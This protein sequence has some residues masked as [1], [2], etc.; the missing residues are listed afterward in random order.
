MN[1]RPAVFLDRDGTI[2][3]EVNYLSDPSQVELLPGAAAA[4]ARWNAEG[5]AVVV[6]TNQAGVARG[7]FAESRIVEVHRRLDELLA[8][9]RAHIDGYYYCPHHPTAGDASYRRD[10]SCRKPLPGMLLHAASEM[11]LDLAAS[12]MIGDKLSDLQ[13]GA[14]AGCATV[15]VRTGYGEEVEG[16]LDH[17][18]LRVLGVADSLMAASQWISF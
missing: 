18:S 12:V 5:T 2:I 4:I 6:V 16:Q 17:Q 7:Y 15:L 9:H 3:R 8:E 14:A 10:C 13:A 1:L 11:S